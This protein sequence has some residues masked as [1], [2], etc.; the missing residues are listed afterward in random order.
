MSQNP[1]STARRLTIGKYQVV[2]HLATGGM[3]AVYKAVDTDLNREVALK[4]LPPNLMAQPAIVE[5]F[6]REAINGAKLRHENVVMLYESSSIN[7]IHYIAFEFVQGIDLQEYVAKKGQLDPAEALKIVIQAVK[8]VGHLCKH[9]IVHRDVKPSNFL[10]ADRDGEPVVKLIDLGLS[11]RTNDDSELRVTK[12]GTTLGTIDYMS[13]EQA[14]SSGNSDFRS[15]L[16][17]LGCTWYHMLAGHPPFPEGTISERLYKHVHQ[18]PPDIRK[19]NK[20][21]PE[22]MATVLARM[23]AKSPADRYQTQEEV[24][25]DLERQRSSAREGDQDLLE[26]LAYAKGETPSGRILIDKKR[27]KTPL[28]GTYKPPRVEQEK[29]RGKRWDKRI[30]PVVSAIVLAVVFLI[31]LVL[32]LLKGLGSGEEPD[33]LNEARLLHRTAASAES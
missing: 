9:G 6:Q 19:I 27:M 18:M 13:P 4:V 25:R 7:G 24:L 12:T 11:R 5:R 2:K 17:S 28:P 3:G 30:V 20:K 8:A 16:Y 23:I 32:A 14:R 21:V 26:G 22:W 1:P 31:L 33:A 15:D 10:I 29:P